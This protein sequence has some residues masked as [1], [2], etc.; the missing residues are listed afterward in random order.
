MVNTAGEGWEEQR[1]RSQPR[2]GSE[3]MAAVLFPLGM[4]SWRAPEWNPTE[5]LCFC[6][7][8]ICLCKALP[9]QVFLCFFLL[10]PFP[11]PHSPLLS[12]PPAWHVA[13][14]SQ[15]PLSWLNWG[16]E[17]GHHSENPCL[18]EKESVSLVPFL[19][20]LCN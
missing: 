13:M 3:G 16:Q 15:I 14:L 9:L 7:I 12:K 1:A 17:L 20:A 2:K 4:Q 11:H 19:A 18:K 5:Q 6:A 8:P 10:L